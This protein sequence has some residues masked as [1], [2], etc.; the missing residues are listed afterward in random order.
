MGLELEPNPAHDSCWSEKQIQHFYQSIKAR[1]T[2]LIGN[3]NSP[4]KK[5]FKMTCGGQ[6]TVPEC[7][8]KVEWRCE[9]LHGV[10]SLK[11]AIRSSHLARK[12][13]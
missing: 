11:I 6:P 9:R 7:E 2:T 3:R 8:G 12:I 13:L 5:L 1:M 10:T 4:K